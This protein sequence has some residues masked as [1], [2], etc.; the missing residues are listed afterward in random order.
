VE[1]Q[2]GE[3]KAVSLKLRAADLAFVDLNDQWVLEPGDFRLSVGDQHT[4]V[5]APLPPGGGS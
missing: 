1:L 2:P 3:T 5:T 4:V